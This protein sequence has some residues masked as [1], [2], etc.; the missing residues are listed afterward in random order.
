MLLGSECWALTQSALARLQGND[1][2]MIRW[3]CNVKA[4]Q[5]QQIRSNTLLEMLNIPSLE[6]LLRANRLRWYGHVER[7]TSW[8]NK[9]RNIKVNSQRKAGRPKKTWQE[10]ITNDIKTWNL[11][12]VDPSNRDAWRQS[13]LNAKTRPTPGKGKRSFKGRRR[14][15]IMGG[16]VAQWLAH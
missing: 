4:D 15:L 14:R 12:D 13:V 8:I 16:L 2:A 7:S 10:T 1:K 6:D 9:C 11:E 3:I 5:I